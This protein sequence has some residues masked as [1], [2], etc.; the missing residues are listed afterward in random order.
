[1]LPR[2]HTDQENLRKR[3]IDTLKI[4][5]DNVS[6]IQENSEYKVEFDSHGRNMSLNVLLTPDFPNEKPVIFV[7]P[8]FPHPWLGEN[9]NQVLGA[10][11]LINYTLH[12]DLGRVVQAIIREFQRT[13]P[14]L[15]DKTT[16]TNHQAHVVV[17]SMVF[18][19]LND[20]TIEELQEV[21]EN[22]DLQ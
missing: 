3:Q 11:G 1:M 16:N 8:V 7:N 18:P 10:P 22:P 5:N 19:D 15:E 20:L 4:F 2:Y 21:L 6:E 14:N 17:N 12:S 13:V 9:S